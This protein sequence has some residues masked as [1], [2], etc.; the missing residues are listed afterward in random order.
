MHTDSNNIIIQRAYCQ[1]QN[2]RT[3][4]YVPGSNVSLCS[5]NSFFKSVL[6]WLRNSCEILYLFLSRNES[7]GMKSPTKPPPTD[8][9]TSRKS[10]MKFLS[11]GSSYTNLQAN[12]YAS[13]NKVSTSLV[14]PGVLYRLSTHKEQVYWG[15][16]NRCSASKDWYE[17]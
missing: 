2:V 9:N 6:N 14:E 5:V 15:R 13:S 3:Y 10:L 17:S 7:A 4:M 16:T 11:H 8:S 12:R 1:I